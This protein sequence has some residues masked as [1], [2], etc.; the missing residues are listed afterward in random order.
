MFSQIQRKSR[1]P[2]DSGSI[3]NIRSVILLLQSNDQFFVGS[4]NPDVDALWLV[5]GRRGQMKNE[6]IDW[7]T[8]EEHEPS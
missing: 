6:I 5:Q 2:A 8:A 3:W 4:L 1:W 7:M